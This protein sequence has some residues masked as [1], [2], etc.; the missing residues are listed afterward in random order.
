MRQCSRG[1]T[2]LELLLVLVLIAIGSVFAIASVDRLAG[3]LDER[4]WAD[5]TQ[6]TLTKLRN[7]AVL[8]GELVTANLD[9][10][11]GKILQDQGD[12]VVQLLVLP[13]AYHFAMP[14]GA[15]GAAVET[16]SQLP[17]YFYPDGTMDEAIFDLVLPSDGRRRYHLQRFT[18]KIARSLVTEMAP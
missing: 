7:Q 18:G 11:A 1:F 12:E 3:R 6:Q 10:D 13:H 5:V 9:M 15:A 16:V 14:V 4:R 2:L 8:R 17:L